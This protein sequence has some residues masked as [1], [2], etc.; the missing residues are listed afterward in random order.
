MSTQ[1]PLLHDTGPLVHGPQAHDRWA[2]FDPDAG[3]SLP[4]TFVPGRRLRTLLGRRIDPNW[5]PGDYVHAV[6]WVGL[7]PSTA[8]EVVDDPT[9]RKIVGFTR[10][11]RPTATHVVLANLWSLRSSEPG[12]LAGWLRS[13]GAHRPDAS[14]AMRVAYGRVCAEHAFSYLDAWCDEVVCAWG[15]PTAGITAR[16]L[17]YRVASLER[18]VRAWIPRLQIGTGD[19][20]RHPSRAGYDLGLHPWN[21]RV[22]RSWR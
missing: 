14:D 5:S 4:G 17:P 2:T 18:L 7:N 21:G 11:W 20:P 19:T 8:D 15:A 12:D 1:P 22:E 3:L 16:Q 6:G 10:R 9:L 13:N